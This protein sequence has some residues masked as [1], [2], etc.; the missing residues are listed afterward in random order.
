VE[1]R[2]NFRPAEGVSD[3]A[4]IWEVDY[5]FPGGVSLKF[6]GVPNGNNQGK[7]TGEPWLYK[8]EYQSKYRRIEDHGTAFEGTNGWVHVDRSGINLQPENLIDLNPDDFKEKLTR[9]DNHV[10]NFLDSIR[11]RKEAICPVDDAVIVDTLCDVADAAMRLGRKLKFNLK[12]E[13]FL[14]DDTANQRLKARPM[15]SPRKL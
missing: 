8:P 1:G 12:A 6:T 4:T 3:T 9:S 5:R 10:R 13:K 11:S 2:G 14:N 15:R 7:G